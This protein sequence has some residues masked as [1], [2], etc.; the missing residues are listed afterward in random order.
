MVV[1]VKELESGGKKRVDKWFDEVSECC[2]DTVC[3]RT[4]GQVLTDQQ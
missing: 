4:K 3:H 1:V 2:Y